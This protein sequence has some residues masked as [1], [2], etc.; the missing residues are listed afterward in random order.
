MLFSPI[1]SVV[2]ITGMES[3]YTLLKQGRQSKDNETLALEPI[4]RRRVSLKYLSVAAQI[5]FG[6]L[7][8]VM[9][10]AS[11][12]FQRCNETQCAFKLSAYSPALS[13]V[14]YEMQYFDGF[15]DTSPYKGSPSKAIDNSWNDLIRSGYVSI[16]EDAIENKLHKNKDYVTIPEEQGGGYLGNLEVYHQLHCLNL[17]RKFTYEGYYR[18][19]S[20]LPMEF[21]DSDKTLR[22]HVDHCIDY[23]RQLI[24]G[25]RDVGIHTYFWAKG[26]NVPFPDFRVERK[27]RD[28]N[29]LAEYAAAARGNITLPSKPE[30]VHEY[31]IM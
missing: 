5:L 29:Q 17:I 7:S 9:F 3:K 24:M 31:D 11:F 16:S 28:W 27:C 26:R 12:R 13:Q 14:S 2:Q 6:N 10:I 15:Y 30:G 18:D 1:R 21:T 22:K 25:T 23:L 20:R 19:P 4:S 8:L